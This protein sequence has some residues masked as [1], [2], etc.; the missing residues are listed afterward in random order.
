M[1]VRFIVAAVATLLLPLGAIAQTTK[2]VVAHSP[3]SE[4]LPAFA[5]K[6]KGIFAK[7]GLDV[8]FQLTPNITLIPVAL[9][10]G[11]VQIG[12]ATATNALLAAEAG[13]DIVSV[14]GGTRLVKSNQRIAL[15]TRPGVTVT[16]A[17]DLRGKKV[18]VP[19]FNAVID[20]VFQKWLLNNKVP[21]NAV[22]RVEVLVP[23]MPDFLKSGQIDAATPIEPI[24]SRITDSGLGAMSVDFWSEV[25]PDIIAA[26]WIAS[27]SW[28]DA[29]RKTLAAWRAAYLEGMEWVKANPDEARKIEVQYLKVSGKSFPTFDLRLEQR[30]LD[31]FQNIALE[32][33]V[34]RKKVD[35][36]RLVWK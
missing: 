8:T 30:D 18:G 27:R 17:D 9:M 31:F 14:M 10:S 6:E 16:K 12:S 22:Q 15:V 11:Q 19:G 3:A 25:N 35:T 36:S 24:V 2:L 26:F 32:L 13:I 33:G 4:F 7:H 1:A 20:V 34:Q 29:N 23:Q 28:A 21:L 5:A